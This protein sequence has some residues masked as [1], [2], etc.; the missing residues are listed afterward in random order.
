M[1]RTCDILSSLDEISDKAQ[2]VVVDQDS[3]S[4]VRSV[5]DKYLSLSGWCKLD[6]SGGYCLLFNN[7]YNYTCDPEIIS[8]ELVLHYEIFTVKKVTAFVVR[9]TDMQVN[10]FSEA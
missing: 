3:D 10:L 6:V 5:K 2:I 8:D 1:S 7:F 9:I 4:D